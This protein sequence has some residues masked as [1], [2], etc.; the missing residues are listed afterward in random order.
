L[1]KRV[2]SLLLVLF[3]RSLFASGNDLNRLMDT[4]FATHQFKEVAISADGSHV[5]WVEQWPLSATQYQNHIFVAATVSG[6]AQRVN[7]GG[8][9]NDHGLTWSPDGKQL[10]FLAD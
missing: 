6:A 9:E 3:C 7:V 4:V 8:S 10:A 2:T 5:A 1:V